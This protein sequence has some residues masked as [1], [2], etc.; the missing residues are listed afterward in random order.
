MLTAGVTTRA[1]AAASTVTV[2]F[3]VVVPAP[4]SVF[5]KVIV[6]GYVP[7]DSEFGPR[8]WLWS[9]LRPD[10]HKAE[11]QRLEAYRMGPVG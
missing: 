8:Y 10:T 4:V 11:P 3:R 7:A 5:V 9:E 6:L 2:A 1:G